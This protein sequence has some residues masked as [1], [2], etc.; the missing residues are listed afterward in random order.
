MQNREMDRKNSPN[1]FNAPVKRWNKHFQAVPLKECSEIPHRGRFQDAERALDAED[2][3][4][5]GA[6]R[7]GAC[8]RQGTRVRR[9]VPVPPCAGTARWQHDAEC[10]RLASRDGE[11]APTL[12]RTHLWQRVERPAAVGSFR[13]VS[14]RP[15]LLRLAGAMRPSRHRTGR[16]VEWRTFRELPRSSLIPEISPQP[17]RSPWLAHRSS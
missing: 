5:Q 2:R 11:P 8:P 10:L 13:L 6:H 9:K 12:A 1:V 7:P 17:V 14:S 15:E 16:D 3:N 4:R